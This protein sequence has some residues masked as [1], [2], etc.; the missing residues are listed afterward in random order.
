[1]LRQLVIVQEEAIGAVMEID[2]QWTS[3]VQCCSFQ[4]PLPAIPI[5]NF[6]LF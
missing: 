3:L 2:V 5:E 1:M 4:L 6:L